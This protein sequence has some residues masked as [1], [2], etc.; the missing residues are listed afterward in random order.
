[1][2]SV[3]ARNFRVLP[4]A[5]IAVLVL[6]AAEVFWSTP[7]QPPRI[8]GYT[9]ITRDGRAK[10]FGGLVAG[11]ERLYI[12][13][14]ELDHFVVGE[15]AD[16]GGETAILPMP[17]HNVGVQDLAPNGSSIL[18]TASEGTSEG[19][20]SLGISLTDWLSSPVGR[21]GRLHPRHGR[22]T[23]ATWFSRKAK[24]SSSRNSDGGSPRKLATVSG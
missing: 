6:V 2:P 24:R 4:W 13:E 14:I 21:S 9:Q 8:T 15:V 7:S 16:S 20:F 23:A 1:M 22:R 5:I 19:R 18:V 11:G 17:F 12:A 3:R 10:G